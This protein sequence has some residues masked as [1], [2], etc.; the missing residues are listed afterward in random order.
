LAIFDPS[1]F[2]YGDT[3][4]TQEGALTNF[5]AFPTAQ[6]TEN[7]GDLNSSGTANLYNVNI[8]N[9]VSFTSTA[10]LLTAN[11]WSGDIASVN[12]VANLTHYLGFFDSSGTGS[13]KPQKTASLSCNP[14]TGTITATTFNGNVSNATGVSLT[15]DDT[16]G[17][18]YIPFSKTIT[19]TA[20]ALYIDNSTTPLNYNPLS[21]T[22]TALVFSGSATT[23]AI[24]DT[25]TN[26]TFYPVFVSAAGTAQTLR[27]DIATGPFAYNPSTGN[28]TIGGTLTSS[29]IA[30]DNTQFGTTTSAITSFTAGV[31]SLA[32]GSFTFR[33]FGWTVT[34]A[35]NTMTG[36]TLTTTR[37]NGVYNVMILNAATGN[38]TINTGLSGG[39][40]YYKYTAPV[41]VLPGDLAVFNINILSV[42]TITRVVVDCYNVEL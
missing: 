7:F 2:L 1:V 6:G 20:N 31:L 15:S 36:L 35:A 25:T 40:Y 32:M 12:T 33:N 28:M 16:S 22:L 38:L 26:A 27:C 19:A 34:G 37:I 10:N 14:S 29:V 11:S 8:D 17:T 24:T 5:L 42:N 41:V 39:T 23:A 4:L 30:P 18:Y 9:Q 3:P 21:S 13:G